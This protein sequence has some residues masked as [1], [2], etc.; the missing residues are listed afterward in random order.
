MISKATQFVVRLANKPGTLARLCSVL[1]DAQVNIVGVFA[2]EARGTALA[3]VMVVNVA[4]AR[5]ALKKA[6]IRFSE[7]EV[8]KVELDNRPGAF[9]GLAGK[10]A[11]KKL[12]IKYAYA[13]TAPFARANVV[14]AVSDI[15]KALAA[16]KQK[17]IWDLSPPR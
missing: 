10:L 7:E 11:Q 3:R 6:K 12:N 4:G 17:K 14:V 15:D 16:L 8:L 9:G 13:T 2:P 1:G 5:A